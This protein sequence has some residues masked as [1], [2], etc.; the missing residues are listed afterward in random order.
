MSCSR[1]FPNR[2]TSPE[3]RRVDE[4]IMDLLLDRTPSDRI[5]VPAGFGARESRLLHGLFAPASA[6][7][8]ELARWGHQQPEM[9]WELPQM[10]SGE[11]RECACRPDQSATWDCPM[12][13]TCGLGH[14]VDW[15]SRISLT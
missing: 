3:Y 14:S 9:P 1:A 8:I 2:A 4:S 13:A 7:A 12:P 11:P 6:H 15:F 10:P 5:V